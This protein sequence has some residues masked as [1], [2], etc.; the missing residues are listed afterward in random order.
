MWIDLLRWRPPAAIVA[1]IVLFVLSSPQIVQGL[2]LRQPG[3]LDAFLLTLG[4]WCISRDRLV[5][6]GIVLAAATLKPQ[7][8]LLPL[9]WCLIWSLCSL[10]KRWPLLVSFGTTSAA[11]V[12]MGEIILPGWPRYFVNGILAYR[13][14]SATTSYLDLALGPVIAPALKA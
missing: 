13:H 5:A 3:M 7:M 14:Y 8:A 10:S 12:A 9:S 6:A 2:R 11:L 1:A 4:A